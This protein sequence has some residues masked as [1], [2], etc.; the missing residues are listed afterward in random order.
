MSRSWLT[1]T[2]LV[3][4]SFLIYCGSMSNAITDKKNSEIPTH[5]HGCLKHDRSLRKTIVI[6]SE[7][8]T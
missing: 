5:P 4:A 3:I 7:Q 6:S 2:N 1:D 8:T